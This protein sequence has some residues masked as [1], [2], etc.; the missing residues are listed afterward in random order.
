ML[1][2]EMIQTHD[3]A[4]RDTHS[5]CSNGVIDWKASKQKT[6]TTSSTEA[7]LLAVSTTAKENHEVDTFLS[8]Y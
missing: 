8:G 5:C 6:V 2:M 7:E 1:P 3:K 4:L